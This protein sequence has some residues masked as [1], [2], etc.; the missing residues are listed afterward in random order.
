MSSEEAKEGNTVRDPNPS[1]YRTNRPAPTLAELER[2]TLDEQAAAERRRVEAR[3]R[4]KA[5]TIALRALEALFTAAAEQGLAQLAQ[6]KGEDTA[7]GQ[8]AYKV[9]SKLAQKIAEGL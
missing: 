6:L 1:P 9:G 5:R 2:A 4:R 7:A 8:L 3:V